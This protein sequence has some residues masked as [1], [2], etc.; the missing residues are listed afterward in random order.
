MQRQLTQR[1][2][3][4]KAQLIAYA[5]EAF[6]RNGYHPTAVADIV[7]GVGVGKG[8][9][10]WY[11]S[12][13][14]ELFIEILR[15]SQREM[16]RRQLAEIADIDDPLERIDIGI[17]TAVHW[18]AE[19]NDLRQLFGFALTE[20]TFADAVRHGQ[21]VMVD[22]ARRH[23]EMA[24]ESGLIPE[25]DPEALAIAMLGV[26]HHLTQVYIAERGEDPNR[27]ADLV[28]EFCKGGLGI[29]VAAVRSI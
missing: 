5:T 23:I 22:D 8:V 3:E 28:A 25:R 2:E 16:R 29:N 18:L 13:K 6:A 20:T 27:V 4:R 9:F 17:R 24:I 26:A 15:S 14:E 7:D 19:N 1:G 11:F 10:Y 21:M 12:S